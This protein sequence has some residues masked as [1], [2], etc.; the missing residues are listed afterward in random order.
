MK[1]L[2]HLADHDGDCTLTVRMS[3]APLA[4]SLAG[5]A[6]VAIATFGSLASQLGES[7]RAVPRGPGSSDSKREKGPV[8]VVPPRQPPEPSPET[9]PAPDSPPSRVPGTYRGHFFEIS[10]VIVS[11]PEESLRA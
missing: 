7:R 6:L 4:M 1:R 9:G 8:A 11:E 5:L 10:N 3:A 2:P